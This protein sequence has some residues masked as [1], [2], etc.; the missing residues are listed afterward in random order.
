MKKLHAPGE[1]RLCNNNCKHMENYETSR[2]MY[3]N[4]RHEQ[5]WTSRFN[6]ENHD[7]VREENPKDYFTT[8]TTYILSRIKFE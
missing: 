2:R 1:Y 5:I 6:R 8:T 7:T 3:P 4:V